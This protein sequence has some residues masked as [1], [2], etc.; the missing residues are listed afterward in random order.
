MN[1]LERIATPSRRELQIKGHQ[2]HKAIKQLGVVRYQV[3]EPAA[4][5]VV[6]A[7][8]AGFGAFLTGPVRGTSDP[9]SRWVQGM[10]LSRS[11]EV[12]PLTFGPKLE[13]PGYFAGVTCARGYD[14][15]EVIASGSTFDY[16]H[17]FASRASGEMPP[18]VRIGLN[19]MLRLVKAGECSIVSAAVLE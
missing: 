15:E 9:A 18:E 7:G 1:K 5:R 8:E 10:Y 14:P 17:T 16:D 19:V 4:V 12:D 11:R 3:T 13:F 2:I 6:W